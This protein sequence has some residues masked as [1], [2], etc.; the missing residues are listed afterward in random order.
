MT[1]LITESVC[2]E[3]VSVKMIIM[4]MIVQKAYVII[5]VMEMEFVIKKQRNANV[6]RD[7]KES[8]AR[9]KYAHSLV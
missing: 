1:A 9:K 3:Y 5:I 2:Q 6:I 4:V 8:F 7:I